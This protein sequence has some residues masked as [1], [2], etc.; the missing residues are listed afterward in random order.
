MELQDY[1]NVV[2]RYFKVILATTLIGGVAAAALTFLM[3]HQAP[4]Y[5]STVQGVLLT[6]QA[7]VDLQDLIE[8]SSNYSATTEVQIQVPSPNMAGTDE[9]Y[10]RSRVTIYSKILG[11]E[12]T[13]ST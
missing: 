13:L 5:T 1:F 11:S 7:A 9:E 3:P 4:G 2:R 12:E 10:T 8:Q 6:N